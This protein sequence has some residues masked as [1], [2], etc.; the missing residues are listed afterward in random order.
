MKGIPLSLLLGLRFS[1]GRRRSGMVS[2]ISVISTMGIALGVAVLIVGL[3]AMNGFETELKDRV[4]SVVPH[5][6]VE[7]VKQ[8]YLNWQTDLQNIANQ[9]HVVATLP[10][11]TFTGLVENGAKMKAI[12]IRGV[13]PQLESETS[14]LPKFVEDNGWQNFKPNAQQIILGK[15][16]A[17]QLEV[18]QGDWVTILIPHTDG[19]NIA[20]VSQPKRVRLQVAGILNLVGDLGYRFAVVPLSDAQ[21]Y[22]DY[23]D[24]ITGLAIQVDDLYQA[25]K[26]V[27]AAGRVISTAAYATSWMSKYGKMHRDIQLVR[28]IMYLAMI[29]V[30]GVACFNIVSTLVMAVKDKSADI[31]ILRTLGANDGLIRAVFIWYGLLA[32][33]LGSVLGIVIGIIMSLQLTNIIHFLEKILDHQF[34]SG[35]IYFIDFLPSELH[36]QDIVIVFVTALILS[37]L[38]S[39]YPAQRASRINPASV[40]SGQ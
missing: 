23:G 24:G 10:F 28:S 31:A 29:L 22:L 36:L 3:S 9:P 33:L 38:A 25:N 34:L 4:L 32:G 20:K 12:Q 30:I 26:L 2:F 8:P 19:D 35:G 5:G 18:K 39:W 40:L 15:G 1:K 27:P 6:E 17:E 11:I 13:D 16:V 37:L 14:A 7:P 21:D